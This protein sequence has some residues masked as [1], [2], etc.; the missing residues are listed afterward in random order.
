MFFYWPVFIY[1]VFFFAGLE[2]I[3]YIKSATNQ[4]VVSNFRLSA[5][6]VALVFIAIFFWY[7]RTV[8]KSFLLIVPITLTFSSALILYFVD[9]FVQEQFLIL[10]ASL[11]FYLAM[12]GAYR[13]RIYH[14]DQTA[15][16]LMAGA[17]AATIF[18][19][20]ASVYAVYLNY[21]IPIWI[22]SFMHFGATALVSFQYFYMLLPQKRKQSL[23]YAV[24]LGIGMTE[25]MFM[26]NFWPFGYLTVGAIALIFYYILWDL[27]QNY[28]LNILSKKRLMTNLITFA[29]LI[30]LILATTQWLPVG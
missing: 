10:I 13:L 24:V 30:G 1:G 15:R 26:T 4:L 11:I 2:V 22:L 23:I 7:K 14:K 8:K 19:F 28:F 12:M 16:G 9:V 18:F 25:I 3:N 17:L 6:A 5:L 27:A 20:Y 29:F 21:S